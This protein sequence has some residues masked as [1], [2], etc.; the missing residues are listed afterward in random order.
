MVKIEKVNVDLLL[1]YT[2][3]Y[4]YVLNRVHNE[5][6]ISVTEKY[7][8]IFKEKLDGIIEEYNTIDEDS[9]QSIIPYQKYILLMNSRLSNI[10]PIYESMPKYN[11]DWLIEMMS[12]CQFIYVCY[13]LEKQSLN[14]EYINKYDDCMRILNR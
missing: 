3:I 12:D 2:T 9:Y 5:G 11:Q 13:I 10:G 7:K 14:D 1:K 4:E 6:I 8:K